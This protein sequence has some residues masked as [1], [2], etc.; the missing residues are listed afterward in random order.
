MKYKI[1]FIKVSEQHQFAG[2]GFAG[3]LFIIL[4][5]L[6]YLSDEDRLFID[7][8]TNECVCTEK[9]TFQN[10]KNCWEYYFTQTKILPD[11]TCISMNS[12]LPA[13]LHYNDKNSFMNPSDFLHL[14]DR[15]Y[16]LF[17]LKNNINETINKYYSENLEGKKTLG[18]QIRLTDMK[19]HHN[20]PG[21]DSYINR[22]NQI[23]SD[24]PEIEQIFL[25]TDDS[26]AITTIKNNINIKVIYYED[27]FRADSNNLHLEQYERYFEAREHHRYKLGVECLQEIFTL[28]K[29]DYLLKAHTSSISIVAVILAENLKKIFK[30]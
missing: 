30:L 4:N 29:C 13:K 18:V 19:H 25:A 21:I 17:K 27:M 20:T 12:L 1:E 11:E 10:T 9:T 23:I 5:A 28:S 3:N 6:T 7:M 14:K 16:S 24:H 8:E 26:K 22:I 2:V 15:F